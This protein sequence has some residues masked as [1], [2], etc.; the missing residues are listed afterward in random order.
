MTASL[1][2]F[3]RLL[4]LLAATGGALAETHAPPPP[5]LLEVPQGALVAPGKAAELELLF[6]GDVIGYI[7]DCG[8]KLNPAGGLARRAWLLNQIKTNYPS[9]PVVLLDSGNYTDNPTEAGEIRTAALLDAM[10]KL[11]YK[12]A[13]VGDR[14]LTLGYEEFQKKVKGLDLAFVSTNIVKEGTTETVFPPYTVVEVKGASGKPVRIGV[15]GLLRYSPVWQK[16]GP[17][18]TNLAVAQP[19]EMLRRVLPEVSAKSDLVVVLASLSKED[20]HELAKQF[21]DIDLLLG[22]YG[23]IYNTV[24]ENEGRVRIYYSGNQGKRIGESRITFDA[25]RN[26]A[27]VTTYMHFLTARYPD[28]KAMHETVAAVNEKLPKPPEPEKAQAPQKL[29]IAPP[30]PGG[31]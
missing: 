28:D 18:G 23:G 31:Q 9:T 25:K 4:L 22:T 1:R 19:A 16:A 27:D 20:A 8:C 10:V 12:A 15:L 24:E 3:T 17:A 21:Q 2:G 13:N 29:A 26:V 30:S 5:R 11:G 6:T 14:D 7:E